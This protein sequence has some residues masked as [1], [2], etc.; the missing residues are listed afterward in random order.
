MATQPVPDTADAPA[1]GEAVSLQS[2]VY[3]LPEAEDTPEDYVPEGFDSVEEFLE[4]A[5]EEY[6]HDRQY[7]RL[8]REAA[9]DDREFF[10]LDQWDPEVLKYREGLPC[11]TVDT[12]GPIVAQVVGD[13]RINKSGIKVLPKEDGDFDVAEVRSDLIRNIEIQSRAQRVY[14]SAFTDQVVCGI[15]AMKVCLKYANDDVFDQD[16]FF[17]K[18]PDPLAVT[19]DRLSIDET[20]RDAV[21]CFV[22]DVLPRT[23]YDKRYPDKPFSA[24][25]A[26]DDRLRSRLSEDDWLTNDTVKVTEYWRMI[27]RKRT[28]AMLADSSV[29]DITDTPVDASMLFIDPQ[30]GKPRTRVVDKRYAQMHLITAKYILEGPYELPIDR[31]PVIKVTGNEIRIGARSMRWGLIRP[32]KD[33]QR[34]KNFWRSLKAENLGYMTNQPWIA[35]E[36]AVEGREQ[37]WEEA[38]LTGTRLLTFKDGKAPPQKPEAPASVQ[39]LIAQEA[40]LNAQ[41]IK[42]TTGVHDASLGVRSNE[43]SGKAILARQREGDV[44]TYLYPDNMN[45]ALQEMGDVAN[46]LL[47]T[48]Y[49]T[50][51]TIRAVGEDGEPRLERINDPMDPKSINLATGKYDVTITTGPSYTTRRVEA[52]EAM[53]AMFQA[54]PELWK[55]WGDLYVK[56][57]DV[58]GADKFAERVKAVM[59]PEITQEEEVPPQ[60]LALQQQMQQMQQLMTAMQ[61]ENEGLKTDKSLEARKLDIDAYGKETDRIKAVTAK[62]FPLGPEGAFELQAIVSQAVREALASPDILAPPVQEMPPVEQP[63]FLARMF[64]RDAQQPLS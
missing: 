24:L 60:M 11:L 43:T 35:E 54:N 58:P 18:I 40:A 6:H 34:L 8:N 62:D 14:T 20:A 16:I 1:D 59:P 49:D 39:A 33:A 64:G 25:T 10:A 41:D 13:W 23:V 57:L 26:Y 48:V 7:D 28:L 12:L 46:Q 27:T 44:S 31:L 15:G 5:R 51:R 37:E 4:D 50:A 29:K 45:A 55:V 42:D 32:A 21:R 22:D 63:G 53:G 9:M 17:E 52:V 38:H 3:A 36:G 19:W 47:P 61:A 2:G 56:M 30:T